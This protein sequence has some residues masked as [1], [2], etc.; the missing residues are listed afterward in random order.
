MRFSGVSAQLT[1]RQRTEIREFVDD[2]P[3]P[4]VGTRIIGFRTSTSAAARALAVARTQAVRRA[5]QALDVSVSD[6]RTDLNAN[7]DVA[8]FPER[9]GAVYL[10]LWSVD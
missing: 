10:T 1:A 4:I 6:R 2:Q 7:G 3:G 9:A 8:T 5:L